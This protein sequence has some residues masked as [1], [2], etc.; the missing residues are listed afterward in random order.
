MKGCVSKLC[1]SS[2][3]WMRPNFSYGPLI[4]CKF[5]ESIVI[6]LIAQKVAKICIFFVS[7]TIMFAP[8]RHFTKGCDKS[9]G[10]QNDRL[11]RLSKMDATKKSVSQFLHPVSHRT[12]R[13]F[14]A[15]FKKVKTGDFVSRFSR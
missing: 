6:A 7:S 15:F 4:G 9:L 12:F 5:E 1:P 13:L 14:S 2:L 3:T 11:G 10:V 8:L